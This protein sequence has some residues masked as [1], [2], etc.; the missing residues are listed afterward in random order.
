[1]YDHDFIKDLDLLTEIAQRMR[2]RNERQIAELEQE[3]E[4]LDRLLHRSE[5]HADV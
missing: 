4:V 5:D 1:M 3:L 2:E